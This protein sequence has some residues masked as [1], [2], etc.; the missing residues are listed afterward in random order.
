[1]KLDSIFIIVRLLGA[2]FALS[3]LFG[4]LMFWSTNHP[5][6][7]GVPLALLL[8]SLTP[9]P[10]IKSHPWLLIVAVILVFISYIM[11]VVPFLNA[12]DDFVARLLHFS[13]LLLICILIFG[14]II[15]GKGQSNKGNEKG[16]G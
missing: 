14:S 11:A 12:E 15:P 16:T 5:A 13:E 10:V 2:F 4:L 6:A 8:L 1:M 7:A 9:K 3:G